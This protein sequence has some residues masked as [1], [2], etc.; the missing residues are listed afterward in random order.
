MSAKVRRIEVDEETAAL[1]EAGAGWGMTVSELVADI[2]RNLEVLQAD[3][4]EFRGNG[5]G[6][7][8]I[9]A[10]EIAELDRR[11]AAIEAGEPTVSNDDVMRWLQ[12]WGTPALSP[13]MTSE[14]RMVWRRTRR[15]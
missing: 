3:L 4:A 13:G 10:D 6:P 15:S 12:T 11:W 1:L 5:E 8:A 2:A 9:P 14:A 7:V